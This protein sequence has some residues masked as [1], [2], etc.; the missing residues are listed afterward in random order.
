[1]QGER[2]HREN[3]Y[4]GP[5]HLAQFDKRESNAVLRLKSHLVEKTRLCLVMSLS[6]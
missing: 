5:F 4:N 6:V 2:S 1:M 3:I